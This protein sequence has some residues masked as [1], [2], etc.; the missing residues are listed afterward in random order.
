MADLRA[1]AYNPINTVANDQTATA[2][3][4]SGLAAPDTI[5][6][7]L[8]N[9]SGF[10]SFYGIGIRNIRELGVGKKWTTVFD[11]LYSGTFDST[12]DDLILALDLSGTSMVRVV[13]T[14]PDS[15]SSVTIN[16]D[17][18]YVARQKK[19]GW[20]LEMEEGRV[21]LDWRKIFGIRIANA[22]A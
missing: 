11:N 5:R 7:G 16:V 9:G 10:A 20:Y 21:I 14:D 3:G 6:A 8:F 1:M 17:D 19:I 22:N 18:Q 15:N 12:A 2:G 13:S 4:D